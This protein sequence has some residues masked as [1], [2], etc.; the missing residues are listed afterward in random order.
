M[1][2]KL[3]RSIVRRIRFEVKAGL[4]KK[5][6]IFVFNKKRATKKTTDVASVAKIYWKR[7]ENGHFG[8]VC[9]P[10]SPT[11]NG[12]SYNDINGSFERQA[13]VR[14]RIIRPFTV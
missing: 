1:W 5:H 7:D 13:P 9:L 8:H 3:S 12:C 4:R 2:G 14:G 11:P 10:H 6:E